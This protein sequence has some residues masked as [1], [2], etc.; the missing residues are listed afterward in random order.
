MSSYSLLLYGRPAFRQ[1][2]SMGFIDASDYIPIKSKSFDVKRDLPLFHKQDNGQRT[3]RKLS[4][5]SCHSCSGHAHCRK[6]KQSEDHNRIQYNIDDCSQSLHQHWDDHI[7]CCLE[8][9]LHSNVEQRSR[10][11]D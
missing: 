4:D 11:M 9:L 5:Q 7:A 1:R 3:G 6:P 10:C 8:H 2:S